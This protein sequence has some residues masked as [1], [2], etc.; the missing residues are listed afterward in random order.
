MQAQ[1]QNF[2]VELTANQNLMQEAQWS[3]MIWVS[4]SL[5][6]IDILSGGEIFH[7][8]TLELQKQIFTT[9][10]GW[11]IL[12]CWSSLEERSQDIKGE[13][14]WEKITNNNKLDNAFDRSDDTSLCVIIFIGIWVASHASPQMQMESNKDLS[15]VRSLSR[16]LYR[17]DGTRLTLHEQHQQRLECFISNERMRKI[18]YLM[19]RTNCSIRYSSSKGTMYRTRRTRTPSRRRSW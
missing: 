3:A 6:K 19:S 13:R 15:V 9:T 10:K 8:S 17:E 1:K 7:S 18:L 16:L 5:Y 14:G 11:Q 12:K 2:L 4:D